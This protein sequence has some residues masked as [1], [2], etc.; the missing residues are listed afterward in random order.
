MRCAIQSVAAAMI[1][2]THLTCHRLIL[3][4][5]PASA[6]EQNESKLSQMDM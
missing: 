4:Q 6:R 1:Y 3:N 2:C 5:Y